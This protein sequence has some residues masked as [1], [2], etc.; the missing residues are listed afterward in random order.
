MKLESDPI[1]PADAQAAF[2]LAH[3]AGAGRRH[4]FME[5]LARALARRRIATWRFDFPFMA[6]GSR[7]PDPPA[8]AQAAVRQAVADAAAAWPGLPLFAGGKSFGGRMSAQAQAQQA[9]DGVRGLVF[10]G[11]PLH[12][13]GKPGL[14]R[15]RPL[16]EVQVPMLFLQGTR[17]ALAELVLVRQALAPLAGRATLHVVEGADHGFDVLVRSGRTAAQVREELADTAAAWMLRHAA[18]RG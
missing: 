14:E 4:P 13:A 5:D 12:P 9:L 11:Y 6:S 17:D 2:V 10:V 3:G 15:A 16:Q 8:L 7:R 1:C 18:A